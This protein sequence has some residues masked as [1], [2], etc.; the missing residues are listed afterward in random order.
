MSA[1][2]GSNALELVSLDVSHGTAFHVAELALAILLF[3]DAARVDVRS[4]RGNASVP[5]RL[6]GVGM[7][8]TS[9]LGIAAGAALLTE[10][11][12]CEARSADTPSARRGGRR[13]RA[14]P[15]ASSLR[16]RT[17]GRPVPAKPPR[18]REF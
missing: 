7:P 17:A 14:A 3:S 8:L 15:A 10:L 4:L 18:R 9:A 5:G 6:L 2:G 13:E 1:R 16:R 12:V 11:E